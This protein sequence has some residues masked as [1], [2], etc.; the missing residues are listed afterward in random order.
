MRVL[1]RVPLATGILIFVLA[2][3]TVSMSRTKGCRR[4]PPLGQRGGPRV[5]PRRDAETRRRALAFVGQPYAG[6]N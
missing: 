2:V 3:S 1:L 4:N 6:L 5:M